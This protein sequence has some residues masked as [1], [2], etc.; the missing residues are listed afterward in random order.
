MNDISGRTEKTTKAGSL[1]GLMR[2]SKRVLL[3]AG[4]MFG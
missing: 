4:N 3:L 2:A 1:S